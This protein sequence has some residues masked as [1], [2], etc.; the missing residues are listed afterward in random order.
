M[1]SIVAE[2]QIH[3]HE[4]LMTKETV[5]HYLYNIVRAHSIEAVLAESKKKAK[6]VGKGKQEAAALD[7]TVVWADDIEL[8]P[9]VM[10]TSRDD[11]F[12]GSSLLCGEARPVDVVSVEV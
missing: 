1:P 11:G 10:P 5:V 9:V 7:D 4:I 2:V 8:E 12:C 3:L 6:P